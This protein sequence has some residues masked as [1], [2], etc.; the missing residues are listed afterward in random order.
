MEEGGQVHVTLQWSSTNGSLDITGASIQDVRG[1]N[2]VNKQLLMQ[3]GA[4]GEPQALVHEASKRN[5]SK[6]LRLQ[7]S[8]ILRNNQR[9]KLS[10]NRLNNR[11]ECRASR[12]PNT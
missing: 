11:S 1:L 5:S 9:C 2:P 3:R 10:S 8:V 4:V 7:Q 12:G 6:S